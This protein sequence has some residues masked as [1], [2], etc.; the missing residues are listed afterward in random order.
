MLLMPLAQSVRILNKKSHHTQAVE[1]LKLWI[2][3]EV[4]ISSVPK[5]FLRGTFFTW[6][7]MYILEEILKEYFGSIFALE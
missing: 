1:Y 7:V 4:F 2:G 5:K 3:Y 6:C